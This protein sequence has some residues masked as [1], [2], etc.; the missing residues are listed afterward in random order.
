MPL[1]VEEIE[2]LVDDGMVSSQDRSTTIPVI[3]L[4]TD[5]NSVTYEGKIITPLILLFCQIMSMVVAVLK[6]LK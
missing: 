6:L 1:S 4:E 3:S 2:S 5:D